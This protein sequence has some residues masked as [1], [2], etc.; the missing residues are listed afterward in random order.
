MNKYIIAVDE[1]TTG[2]RAIIFDKNAEIVAQSYE[3]IS[4]YF[5][6]PGWCEQDGREIWE[7]CLI[8]IRNVLKSSK[9]KPEQ[10]SAIGISSQRSS[11]L[12]W[13]KTN[14]K[15]VYN[16]ITWQ[17]TRTAEI[18]A[19][20]DNAF[21][22]KSIRALGKFTKAI[23]S[24]AT[25]IRKTTAGARLITTA[26]LSFPTASSLA[27]TKWIFDNID[28]SKELE[29][30]GN[31]LN[32]TID[33]WLIWNLTGGKVHATDYSNASSTGMFD[34][35]KLQWSNFFLDLFDVNSD[36]LPEV[37]ETNGDFGVTSKAIFGCEIPIR[38]SV[39]DQQSSLFAA[40][41]FKPGDVKLTNGTGSF[42]DMNVGYKPSPSLNKLIPLIAWRLNNRTTFMLEG[43]VNTTGAAVQWL[44]E[45]LSIID[46]E[47]DSEKM[48]YKVEDTG[49]VYFVPAFTGLSSPYWDP[50]AS[51]IVIGLNRRTTREHIVR[52]ALEGIAFR[53]KDV[54][55]AIE[56][57]SGL[58]ISLIRAD[59]GASKNNF[60]LQFIADMLNVEVER[61]V[62]LDGTALGAAY[63]AGL[64]SGYW[65]SIDELLKT[66]KLDKTF[67]PLMK[68]EKREMLY[69]VWKDAVGRSL[70][71]RKEK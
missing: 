9:I 44:K 3:K 42:I 17:D 38:C 46:R 23:S 24:V 39:A 1:G 22:M 49:G 58:D 6:H 67:V 5:P 26:T 71:W 19:E 70:M 20:K 14:G 21:K 43:M 25:G 61:P 50:H 69:S 30:K 34:S 4:Q 12:L 32:G 68:K 64:G 62:M 29:N 48:A 27:H 16:V 8:V 41:C 65:D 36:I 55:Q 33:T 52:A 37:F 53:C 28:K 10:I 15:P 18:C 47:E 59:G 2:I 60:L 11:N 40:G 54:I 56:K 7:K 45:N 35:F 13:D 63:F 51:G 57:S 31:L 66:R